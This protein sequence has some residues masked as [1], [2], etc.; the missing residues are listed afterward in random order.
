MNFR[1]MLRRVSLLPFLSW[2]LSLIFL[3]GMLFSLFF[4]RVAYGQTAQSTPSSKS[5]LRQHYDAAY[6]FQSSGH[7]TR[8][9]SEYKL[10]LAEA[11]HRLANGRA[12]IGDYARAVPFYDEALKLAPDFAGYFDYAAAAFDAG[13][14]SKAKLLAQNGLSLHAKNATDVQNAKGHLTL[15]RALRSMSEKKEATLRRKR[16]SGKNLLSSPTTPSATQSSGAS[17]QHGIISEK[18]NSISIAPL[19]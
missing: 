14:P 8:A 16:S 1:S 12:N 13:D 2:P 18:R 3:G 19:R 6:R 10:F 11:L 7:L 9:D 15:G 4:N 5:S 17:Q